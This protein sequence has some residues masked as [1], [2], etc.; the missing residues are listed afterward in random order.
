MD[1]RRFEVP[2]IN[3]GRAFEKLLMKGKHVRTREHKETGLSPVAV[4][5]YDLGKPATFREDIRAA[6]EVIG[7]HFH[8]CAAPFCEEN[9][10]H[11][12]YI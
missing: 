6:V 12:I 4:I 3:D 2:Q 1:H 9:F 5:K 10:I 11:V 7:G 8:R